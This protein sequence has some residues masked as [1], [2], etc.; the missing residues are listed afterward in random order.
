MHF[1]QKKVDCVSVM[2]HVWTFRL[3][4]QDCVFQEKPGILS[5]VLKNKQY[6][7]AITASVKHRLLKWYKHSNVKQKV[8]L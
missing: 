5:L 2:H 6:T 3:L 7:G 8:Q 1:S 4:F